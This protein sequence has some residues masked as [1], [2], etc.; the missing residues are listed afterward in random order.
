MNTLDGDKWYFYL[1]MDS[2][3]RYLIDHIYINVHEENSSASMLFFSSLYG[4]DIKV[5]MALWKEYGY[6]TSLSILWEVWG[7]L[8]LTFFEHLGGCVLNIFGYSFF[9][10]MGRI[11][12]RA[13]PISLSDLN[14]YLVSD[15]HWMN[16]L[17]PLYFP[18]Q[19]IW[20]SFL[21]FM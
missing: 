12:L 11:L 21:S 8:V 14:R 3:Y 13:I 9:F 19:W 4:S 5:T 15:N 1:F 18:I 6:I 10:G 16:Y 2:V 7:E 17:L 20:N